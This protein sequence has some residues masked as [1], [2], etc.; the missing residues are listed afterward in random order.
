MKNL[1]TFE[2]FEN[3]SKIVN[4]ASDL[5]TGSL[6]QIVDNNDKN[7]GNAKINKKSKNLYYVKHNYKDMKI[8]K[9]DVNINIHG[10]AQASYDKLYE[11]DN[12]NGGGDYPGP[13]LINNA[14]SVGT[15][16]SISGEN[17][18]IGAEWKGTGPS[19][20]PYP[21]KYRQ[22]IKNTIS[23]ESRRRKSAIKKLMKLDKTKAPKV[24]MKSFDD[25][26]KET[27]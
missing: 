19:A 16:G 23:K 1:K 18:T 26:Q 9:S 12:F 24:K 10:Q 13:N 2:N 11:L 8:K 22:K 25:F 5:N 6:I 17:T 14:P 15:G 20:T 27:E 4:K 3:E 7:T 21:N